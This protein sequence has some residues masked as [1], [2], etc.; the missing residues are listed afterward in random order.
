YG[1]TDLRSRNNPIR[2]GQHLYSLCTCHYRDIEEPM[3]ICPVC[4]YENAFGA[5]ICANCYRLLVEVRHGSL[6]STLQ[7]PSLN[8]PKTKPAK[9]LLR[10]SGLLTEHTLAFLVDGF[11][12]PLL[13]EL[14]EQ[15]VLGRYV[16]DAGM[17]PR[18]DLSPYGAF[19]TG[20]SR[21][22]AIIRRVEGRLFIEDLGARNGTWLNNQQL[23]PFVPSALKSGDM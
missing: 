14:S 21:R 22:H 15:A 5:L 3:S 18:V 19:E 16:A 7:Q 6:D 23:T 12:E 13:L 17:Q 2:A 9:R 20:I 8:L 10:D 11:E 4:K 1:N